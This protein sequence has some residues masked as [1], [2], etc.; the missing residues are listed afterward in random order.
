MEN[1]AFILAEDAIQELIEEL[2]YGESD[3]N[4]KRSVKSEAFDIQ[5]LEDQLELG[6]RFYVIGISIGSYVAWS[7]LKHIPHKYDTTLF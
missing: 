2:G 3:P 7:C 5:E 1:G 4:P 6:P